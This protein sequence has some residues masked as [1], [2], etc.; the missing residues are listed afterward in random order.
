[1]QANK[2]ALVFPGQGSQT[3]GM[4]KDLY[5]K[6]G[7]AKNIFDT[8][9]KIIGVPLSKL[10]FEGPQDILTDTI[11][12]QPAIMV[13]SI[14]IFETLKEKLGNR[15][16]R[17]D[18][19]A[20][21]SLG[22]Y[23]ALVTAGALSFDNAVKLVRERGRLMKEADEKSPGGMAAILGLDD[24]EVDKIV[25]EAQSEGII[26]VAN[27]NCP[28][29][30]VISGDE[31]GL[32]KAME[33]ANARGAKKVVR[34]Q[35]SIAAHSPLMRPALT[36]LAQ[37]IE[38]TTFNTASVPVIANVTGKPIS[39]SEEIKAE[40]S[41]QLCASVLWTQSVQNMI[42][43]GVDTFIEIGPGSTLT[44]L[45]KR[46]NKDVKLINISDLASIDDFIAKL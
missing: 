16:F 33:L 32:K 14:A 35:I 31:N 25:K 37:A 20:G 5:E 45:I 18:M 44:G 46:I 34:L 29:Q 4:G 7:T 2:I 42:N 12:A 10:C 8:A 39:T 15:T 38:K 40:L 21:H 27:Y 11:N 13:T 19:T 30:I 22:E 23:T 41:E 17:F 43:M 1:M 9:D 28:G 24:S 26:I 36:E 6:S 3:V